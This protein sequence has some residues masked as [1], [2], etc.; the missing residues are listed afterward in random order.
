MV[1]VSERNIEGKWNEV[2]NKPIG[3]LLNA[4]SSSSEIVGSQPS[5]SAKA[6]TRRE[7]AYQGSRRSLKLWPIEGQDLEDSVKSS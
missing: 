4:A 3:P 1:Q 2:L 7:E 5:T 6:S